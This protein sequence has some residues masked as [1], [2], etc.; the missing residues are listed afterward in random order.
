MF[1]S[2]R[3]PYEQKSAPPAS[4][5][6]RLP[7]ALDWRVMNVPFVEILPSTQA[8]NWHEIVGKSAQG[9]SQSFGDVV[10]AVG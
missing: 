2:R 3:P 7:K 9:S 10:L 6:L 8:I 1:C 5:M 4:W